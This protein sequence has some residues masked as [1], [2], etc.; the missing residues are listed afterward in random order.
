MSVRRRGHGLRAFIRHGRSR[1]A[2][3]R[4]ARHIIVRQELAHPVRGHP[5]V[6]E[7]RRAFIRRRS[8]AR[9]VVVARPVT[10]RAAAAGRAPASPSR[11]E[12][13]VPP[14]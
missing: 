2:F 3:I 9:R 13:V 11:D 10:A 4:H 5:V 12:V 14:L 1:R 7:S 8:T 6:E